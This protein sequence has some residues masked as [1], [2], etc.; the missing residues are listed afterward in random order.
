MR[1]VL[2]AL[3]LSQLALAQP[4]RVE[5]DPEAGFYWPFYYAV[6]AELVA[7]ISEMAK[8]S[9]GRTYTWVD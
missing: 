2:L 7:S 9:W 3:L 8:D 1:L 4:V 5:A 6:P